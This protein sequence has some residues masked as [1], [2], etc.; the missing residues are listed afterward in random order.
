MFGNNIPVSCGHVAVARLLLRKG[1][2]LEARN[3][4]GSRPLHAASL[5][6]H[7]NVVRLL[8]DKGADVSAEADVGGTPLH[9]A[10]LGGHE[11]VARYS[12]L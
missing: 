8:L 12:M 6:G 4:K 7:E 11:G 10:A 2:H 1:A 9:A 5:S 3:D